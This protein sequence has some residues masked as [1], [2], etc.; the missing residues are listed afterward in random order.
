GGGNAVVVADFNND[1]T[2]DLA[3]MNNL[4]GTI[5]VLLGNGDG[6][7]QPVLSYIGGAFPNSVAVGDFNGDG[8]LDLVSAGRNGVSVLLNA[9]HCPTT[10][11][12]HS[13]ASLGHRR[14]A[15][16]NL[17][18]EPLT[19]SQGA[20]ATSRDKPVPLPAVPAVASLP[21]LSAGAVDPF[22][23]A[24]PVEDRRLVFS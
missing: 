8:F 1:G 24:N 17:L 3:V 22:L 11:N 20:P 14:V 23:A 15:A 10:P 18:P 21:G 12:I 7:F 4:S 6:S 16:E 2:T 5:G 9:A 13:A 19:T